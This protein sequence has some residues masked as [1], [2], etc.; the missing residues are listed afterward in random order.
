MVKLIKLYYKEIIIGLIVSILAT[1]IYQK[2]FYYTALIPSASMQNTLMIGDKLL[3]S[4]D[5]KNLKRG[6]IY[7]FYKGK[8]LYI[9]RLI[10][11]P[12]DH[13]IIKNDDVFVND[14]KLIEPYVSSKV[15]PDI[16]LDL[17]IP[18]GKYFFLG[19]NRDN[20]YDAR[21]WDDPFIDCEQIDGHAVKIISPKEHKKES[22]NLEVFDN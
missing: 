19:D 14:V 8:M 7:T 17:V 11:L 15:Y 21:F 20:S 2:Y 5:L 12:G 10:G 22:L 18:D 9:K 6:E 1:N 4:K 16:Q 3:I 13:V